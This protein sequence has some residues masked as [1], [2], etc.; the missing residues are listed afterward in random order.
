[1]DV[2]QNSNDS[3]TSS[4]TTEESNSGSQSK[5]RPKT[6]KVVPTKTRFTGNY[7]GLQLCSLL[8]TGPLR[9]LDILKADH[10]DISA[11]A[12]AA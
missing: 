5:P 2:D 6:V 9:M 3:N 12:G 1:M 7:I 10:H 11:G 4:N 8:W